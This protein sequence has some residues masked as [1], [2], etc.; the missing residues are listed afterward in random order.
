LG[1][2]DEWEQKDQKLKNRLLFVKK[3]MHEELISVAF[4]HF[5]FFSHNPNFK[6]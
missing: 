6:K 4:H 3:M 1:Q 5:L 2:P